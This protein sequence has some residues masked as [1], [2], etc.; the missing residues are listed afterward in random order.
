M[1]SSMTFCTSGCA[2]LPGWPMLALR[3][4][5]PMNTPSTPGVAAMASRFF[6]ASTVSAC[7]STHTRSLASCTYC[8][9]ACQREARASA[10]PMP[11][12]PVG[13]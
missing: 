5:G 10:L 9:C 13:A 2:A 3:S 11:R 1:P 12:T 7:T 8:G 6:I 4:A